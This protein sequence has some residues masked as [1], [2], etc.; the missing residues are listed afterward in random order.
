MEFPPER[1]HHTDA[2]ANLALICFVFFFPVFLWPFFE[3]FLF[4]ADGNESV[5]QINSLARDW[6]NR[7]DFDWANFG[8][9]CRTA[10]RQRPLWSVLSWMYVLYV[11]LIAVGEQFAGRQSGIYLETFPWDTVGR[12]ECLAD[13]I[14]WLD[15]DFS[16][17]YS[18]RIA[19]WAVISFFVSHLAGSAIQ[20]SPPPDV[21]E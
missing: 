18:V 15:V 16:Y 1:R 7:L 2:K 11:T 6:R 14:M 19:Y 9:Q 21:T 3:V 8:D 17:H 13:A 12:F 5:N 10:R 4:M 20:Q